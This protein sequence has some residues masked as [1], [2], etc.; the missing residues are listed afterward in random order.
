[1]YHSWNLAQGGLISESTTTTFYV[2]VSRRLKPAFERMYQK[3]LDEKARLSEKA[4][5]NFTLQRTKM[6]LS[7]FQYPLFSSI[8]QFAPVLS[9][10]FLYFSSFGFS[11]SPFLFFTFHM[12]G[13]GF[14]YV[15]K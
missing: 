4:S 15:A 7:H 3:W 2:D 13:S 14:I 12:T 8:S 6:F 5:M 11:F 9:C 10:Y 1:L